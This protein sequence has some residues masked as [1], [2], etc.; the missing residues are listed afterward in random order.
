MKPSAFLQYSALNLSGAIAKPSVAC[1]GP[2]L[3][4]ALPAPRTLTLKEV[5]LSQ[6]RLP[7]TERM[8]NFCV[9]HEDLVS[10]L[11][12]FSARSTYEG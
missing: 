7:H 6:F 5:S 10:L 9:P 3:H 11:M 4:R 8:G 12:P 2:C 1:T